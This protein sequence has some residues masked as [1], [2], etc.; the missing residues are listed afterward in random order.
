MSSS[1]AASA[2][3]P[4]PPIPR[5]D[6]DR[7]VYAGT[8]PALRQANDSNE[9][10][11]DPPV[12]ISDPY[13]WMRDD[14]RVDAGVLKYLEDEN[15]YSRRVTEHLGGLQEELYGEFLSG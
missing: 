7:Y 8:G 10:L 11:M 6:E 1:S 3:L 14:D 9:T 4:S 2:M 12:P 13:G 15:E 5:R